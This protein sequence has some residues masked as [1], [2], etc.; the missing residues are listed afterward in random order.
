MEINNFDIFLDKLTFETDFDRYIVHVLKRVKDEDVRLYGASD[1]NRLI[2]TFYV[3]SR[4]YLE[5]KIPVIKDLCGSNCARAYI[6]PQVRNNLDCLINLAKLTLD[7]LQNPTQKP[8]HLVRSAYC[9][10]HKS[11]DKRWI[12]DLDGDSMIERS[13]DPTSPT[14]IKCREWTLTKVVDLVREQLSKIGKDPDSAYVVPTVHGAHVVTSPFNLQETFTRCNLMFEGE[15]K[16]VSDVVWTGPGEYELR[17]KKITG[18]LHKDGMSLL[19]CNL[20]DVE[21]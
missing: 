20:K 11:R 17:R 18:W 2:K 1:K 5:R 10:N 8:D 19:Y 9:G 16:D 21:D 15:R 4:E 6:L 13:Y 7:N 12:I 3:S 14:E